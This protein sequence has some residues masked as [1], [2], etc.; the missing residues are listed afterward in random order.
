MEKLSVEEARVLG[1]LIEKSL[2][3]PDYYPLTLNSLRLACNQKS[4]RE[5]IT[6]FDEETVALAL[7]GLK[8]KCLVTFSPYGSQGHLFKYRHFLLDPR[9]NFREPE[10]S[11]LCVLLLRGS[12]TLNELKIRTTSLHAFSSLEDVESCLQ[13]LTER[14]EPWVEKLEKRT[15]WKEP[16]WRQLLLE[17]EID[18]NQITPIANPAESGKSKW[19]EFSAL[20]EEVKILRQDLSA[21]QD[22]VHKLHTE[23]YGSNPS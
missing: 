3:T 13:K 18:E 2:A 19:D 21:L 23:L 15:G 10:L 22:I 4:S 20:Q 5:P 1:S 7:A 12:Q 14:E 11:L 6:D 16:R 17:I 9:F 8:Q